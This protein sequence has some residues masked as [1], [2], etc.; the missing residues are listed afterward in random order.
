M[1][2]SVLFHERRTALWL[3]FLA[4]L[5]FS[6]LFCF[7]VY[8]LIASDHHAVLDPDGYG[9]LGFGLWKNGSL[10]FYPNTAPTVTRGPAY[11]AFVCLLL[12]VTGGWWPGAVQTAQC[13]LFA[14][15]ALLVFRTTEA[16]RNRRV[17]F[18][19]AMVF[20]LYPLPVWFTSRIWVEILAMFLLTGFSLSLILC[21]T[22][23]SFSAAVL[24]GL[25]LGI[26]TLCKSTFLPF[27]VIA[28][29]LVAWIS[30]WRRPAL[31]ALLIPLTALLVVAPWTARNWRVSGHAIPVHVLTGAALLDGDYIVGK[32]WETP[33]SYAPQCAKAATV[34][35][36]IEE[37]LPP[38]LLGA[39]RDVVL[40]M[41]ILENRLEVYTDS[42]MLLIR[43]MAANTILFWFLGESPAKSLAIGLMLLPLAGLFALS[44]LCT[45][46]WGGRRNALMIPVALVF[47]YF[48]AHLPLNA[49]ARYSI[50]LLPLMMVSVGLCAAR[51]SERKGEAVSP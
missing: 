32:F 10:S 9:R 16:L 1:S 14:L 47:F 46:L 25:I 19:T 22:K 34:W 18:W 28:P 15:T 7:V 11:P 45:I 29:L 4:A 48:A 8:P 49:V 6:L 5:T 21:V 12:T 26:A 42:P 35:K 27:F 20:A 2:A 41:A 3:P 17:A 31:R 44:A 50:P 51:W 43:K 36:K 23:P 33:F 40:D 39:E 30:G 24:A 38:G 37:E 13:L